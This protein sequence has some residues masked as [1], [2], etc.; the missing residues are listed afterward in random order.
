[1]GSEP[2]L[3]G[4]FAPVVSPN[5]ECW[6]L[7]VV[8][9]DSQGDTATTQLYGGVF[10][11]S[12][13]LLATLTRSGGGYPPLAWDSTGVL[14][15]S[16]PENVGGGG[17]GFELVENYRLLEVVLLNPSTGAFASQPLCGGAQAFQ[18]LSQDGEVMACRTV[19][20]AGRSNK[21]I[22]VGPPGGAMAAIDT[23]PSVVGDVAITPDD[24]YVTYCTEQGVPGDNNEDDYTETLWSAQLTGSGTPVSLMTQDQGSDCGGYSVGDDVAASLAGSNVDLIDLATGETTTIGTA[25]SVIGVL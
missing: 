8:T 12:P 23:S 25:D 14:L 15:G 3:T 1:M 5:G 9:W 24:R 10:G 7:S 18:A 11:S 4:T 20:A 16:A 17:P 19:A 21:G 22:E 13:T 6:V 2:D